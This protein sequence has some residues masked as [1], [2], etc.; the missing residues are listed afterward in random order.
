MT[1]QGTPSDKNYRLPDFKAP[2][3]PVKRFSDGLERHGTDPSLQEI[4]NEANKIDDWPENQHVAEVT[5]EDVEILKENWAA[6]PIWNL[7]GTEGF[8][9]YQEELKTFSDTKKAE[10]KASHDQQEQKRIAH[11]QKKADRLGCSF[12]VAQ[13]ITGLEDNIRKLQDQI[14]VL[15]EHSDG[16]HR[17]IRGY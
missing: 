2:L 4:W 13:Y 5:R 12:G 10:W 6:D 15:L 9:E 3:D 1:Q 16:A 7:E 8:E 17:Q 11:I 14:D